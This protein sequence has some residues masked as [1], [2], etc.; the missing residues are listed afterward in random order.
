PL[1]LQARATWVAVR[2]P[3]SEVAVVTTASSSDTIVAENQVVVRTARPLPAWGGAHIPPVPNV[4]GERRR[5]S[6]ALSEHDVAAFAELTG[7]H[8][9]IHED[10]EL[11]WRLGLAN[12]LVQELT[13]LLIMMHVAAATSAGSI[14]M[15]FP[16]PV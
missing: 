10:T 15:W 5:L 16:D 6:F 3:G 11:A 1:E 9:P 2:S 12:V 7:I 4:A 13:L 8:E 14:E